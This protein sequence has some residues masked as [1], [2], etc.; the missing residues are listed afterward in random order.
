MSRVLD[1]A[2]DGHVVLGAG[3]G[4]VEP[5][6]AAALVDRAEVH[7]HLAVGAVAVADAQDDDVPLV[8]LDVLQVLDQQADELAVDLPFPFGIEAVAE[9]GV[10]LG[11]PLQGAFDLVLLGFG[12]GDDADAPAAL[13]AQQFAHELG[14]VVGLG[15][16]APLVVDAVL[17]AVEADRTGPSSSSAARARRRRLADEDR[18]AAGRRQ[19]FFGHRQQPAVVEGPVGEADQRFAA[20]A[21]VPAEHGR[22]QVLGGVVEEAVAGQVVLDHLAGFLDQ[23][24]LF[25]VGVCRAEKKSVGGSCISSPTTIACGRGRP[26][27]PPLPA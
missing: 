26:R 2:D 1:R 21:V 24:F 23:Q 12:K 7:Q 15:A 19:A 27:A 22:G 16:V 13:P 17:H 8:A 14:D 4:H 18:P 10:V 3:E 6:L 5:P 11:Q 20:A 9:V 25:L